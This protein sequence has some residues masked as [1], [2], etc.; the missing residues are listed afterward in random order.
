M[1][2]ILKL[3]LVALATLA[4]GL[5][6]A[7]TFLGVLHVIGQNIAAGLPLLLVWA[8]VVAPVYDRIMRR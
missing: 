1:I 3:T 6:A 4:L 8:F 7:A 5:A 2:L